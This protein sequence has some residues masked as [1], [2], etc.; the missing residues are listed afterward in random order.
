MAH[1]L[2]FYKTPEGEQSI[3]VVFRDENFWMTQKP[4][5]ELFGVQR[6]AITKHL[7]N[8]FETGELEEQSVVSILEHTTPHGA[9]RV[10]DN[11]KGGGA[12]K[13]DQTLKIYIAPFTELQPIGGVRLRS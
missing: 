2:I 3:E 6:P 4:S 10:R 9:C 11:Q 1:E 7:K 5:A 8:I 12:F 13:R